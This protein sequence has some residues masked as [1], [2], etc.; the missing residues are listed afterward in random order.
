MTQTNL[1]LSKGDDE[2]PSWSADGKE[3]L[4]VSNRDGG[5]WDIYS[6][7]VDGGQVTRLTKDAQHEFHPL[8]RP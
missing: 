1:S 4:F 5:Q 7:T 8:W 2:T 6:M 3:I